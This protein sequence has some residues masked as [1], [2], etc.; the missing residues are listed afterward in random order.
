MAGPGTKTAQK[1]VSSYRD[2]IAWQKAMILA[3][4]V[5]DASAAFPKDEIFGLRLQVRRAA[6]SVASNIAEG[7]ARHA[8]KDFI[9]FLRISRGSLAELETQMLLARDFGFITHEACSE[10]LAATDE[11]GRI[12]AGLIASLTE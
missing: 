3:R 7:H 6:V 10:I 11:E 5:Y 4:K 12:L 2:L 8:T 9:H 1:K